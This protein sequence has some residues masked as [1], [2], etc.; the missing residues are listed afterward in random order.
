MAYISQ[1]WRIVR[2]AGAN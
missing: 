2:R 1:H